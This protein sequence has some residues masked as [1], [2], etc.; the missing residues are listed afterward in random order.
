MDAEIKVRR[1]NLRFERLIFKDDVSVSSNHHSDSRVF[2]LQFAQSS[3]TTPNQEVE[4][5]EKGV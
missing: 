4:T 1:G 5:T 2:T 3:L